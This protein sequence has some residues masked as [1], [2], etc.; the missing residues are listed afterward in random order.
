MISFTEG[1]LQTLMQAVQLLDDV[2]KRRAFLDRIDARLRFR[3]GALLDD[4]LREVVTGALK[5]L[6]S[7]PAAA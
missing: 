7:G 2:G 3:S 4:D 1:Q 5:G 6:R